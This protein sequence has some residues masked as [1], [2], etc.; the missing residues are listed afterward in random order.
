MPAFAAA[1]RYFNVV[2]DRVAP[3]HGPLQIVTLRPGRASDKA[4]DAVCVAYIGNHVVFKD[5]KRLVALADQAFEEIIGAECSK[6]GFRSK[7]DGKAYQ[8]SRCYVYVGDEILIL[9]DRETF[10]RELIQGAPSDPL[11]LA[12]FPERVEY[13]LKD[14]IGLPEPVARA[15]E[16]ERVSHPQIPVGPS[17]R[18]PN[19]T[20][21][22]T[23]IEP[24]VTIGLENKVDHTYYG[25]RKPAM[26]IFFQTQIPWSDKSA[27]R[28]LSQKVVR[29]IA[30]ERLKRHELKGVSTGAFNEPKRS[31]FHFRLSYRYAT[32]EDG[33]M[34]FEN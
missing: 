21:L 1:G 5:I 19:T 18:E 34:E 23:E 32:D 17:V 33:D 12:T 24:G 29:T 20:A 2:D 15:N 22:P 4:D 7:V 9:K 10:E 31:R 11:R 8:I 27:Q 13:R 6:F 28:A 14:N 3:A 16:Y 30:G 25:D 26:L